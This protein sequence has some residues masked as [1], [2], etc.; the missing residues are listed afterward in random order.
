MKLYTLALWVLVGLCMSCNQ[1]AGSSKESMALIQTP[2][3]NIKVKLYNHTPKHKE[4]FI[5]LVQQGY[6]DDLL[7]HRVIPSFMMQGGD[8]N[9]KNAPQEARL[10]NGG[11]GYTLPAEIKSKHFKGAL[12]AARLG[13]AVNPAKESSGSQFYIVQGRPVNRTE[14]TMMSRGKNIQYSEEEMKKYET[15]GGTPFLDGDYTVFGEVVEGMEVVDAIC[16]QPCDE[17]NR[18]TT[19]ITMKI[20]LL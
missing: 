1:K 11:P 3:G 17:A 12:A 2:L 4:N 6:Y 16:V 5:K 20:K 18:P 7:F 15:L 9:S 10:G 13:D 8:P 19:N 14:L